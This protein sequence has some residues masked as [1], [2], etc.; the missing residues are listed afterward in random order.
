MDF[1]PKGPTSEHHYSEDRA[2]AP[3]LWGDTNMQLLAPAIK[4]WVISTVVSLFRLII[5][6]FIFLWELDFN[7]LCRAPHTTPPAF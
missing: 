1:S 6:L 3:E 5:N 2:S 4:F 7:V